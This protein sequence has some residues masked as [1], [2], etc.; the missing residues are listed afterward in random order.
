MLFHRISMAVT[1]LN[2]GICSD[3]ALTSR[4]VRPHTRP[5]RKP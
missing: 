5:F 1:T 2:S 4:M 3:I